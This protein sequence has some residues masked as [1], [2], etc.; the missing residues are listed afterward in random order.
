MRNFREEY[1]KSMQEIPQF[2]MEA[3]SVR[4]ELHHRKMVAVKRRKTIA[5]VASAACL[6]LLC[7]VGTVTAVNYHSSRIEIDQHGFAFLGNGAARDTAEEAQMNEP[8]MAA[9][10]GRDEDAMEAYTTGTAEG[11][12]AAY[13]GT[14]EGAVAAYKGT[15]GGAVDGGMPEVQ[16]E[17]EVLIEERVY[18]SVEA[19]RKAEDVVIAIPQVEWLGEADDLE[20]QEV[21]VTDAIS[22]VHVTLDFGEKQFF[23][24]QA[25]NRDY[26]NYASSVVFMGD[27]AN[28]RQVMN[29]QG[30]EYQ[31]F[32]S[33]ADGEIL[34]THAAMSVNGR[35]LTLSFWGYKS[36][37]VDAVLKQLDVSIYF[38]EP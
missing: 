21:S 38:V 13:T 31:V 20:R 6:L 29:E 30:L 17:A 37:E 26:P 28:K 35:D 10:T 9:Y 11:A 23:M 12:A 36:E 2:H 27:A 18:D 4:D 19:F 7:S 16:C 14:A 24:R 1:S 15:E 33:M 3:A 8:A 34:S 22:M 5:S 25:D 32:D